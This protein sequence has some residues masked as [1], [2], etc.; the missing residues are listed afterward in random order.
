MAPEK[1]AAYSQ[2][3]VGYYF[4]LRFHAMSPTDLGTG[5]SIGATIGTGQPQIVARLWYVSEVARRP[6]TPQ[7]REM[8]LKY[9]IGEIEHGT[10]AHCSRH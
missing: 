5:V 8:R 4:T 1:L 6:A 10:T 9:Q 3:D 2:R 7:H